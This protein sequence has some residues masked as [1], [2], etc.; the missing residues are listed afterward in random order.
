VARE[1]FPDLDATA[2]GTVSIGRRLQDPLSE[3]VKIEPQHLGVGM[4][5]HDVSP[6]EL[7]ESLDGVVISCVNFVGV[8]LNRASSALLQYVS[9]LNQLIAR[10]VVAWRLEN[11]PFRSR[12]DLLKVQGVGPT[13][14][15]QA[16]GFLRIDGDEPLDRT[17]IHPESYVAARS[18]LASI[19]ADPRDIGKDS[20][21]ADRLRSIPISDLAGQLAVGVPTLSDIVDSLC[22]PE[23]D[24]R[25][26]SADVVFRE[27]VLGL[28]D[29]E[30]GME[31][32]GAVLN[33]VDFGA[34]VDIG[35]KDSALIHVSQMS[36]Q[37]V[38]STH[39]IV[40]VGDIVQAWV[41]SIDRPRKRVGL[42][43]IPPGA[44]H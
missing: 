43:L 17:A 33:V 5:Q 27:G 8:D 36:T 22:R 2:R 35:L 18:V 13:T 11:G 24:P 23:R 7:R 39:D 41:L 38:R 28:D 30:V 9:G 4:Y 12:R 15:Q 16:A 21:I 6:T 34:F 42:T 31:V 14:F 29:L 26:E 32:R 1:E 25:G 10:R 40:R 44:D 20:S 3:L 19:S 37:F